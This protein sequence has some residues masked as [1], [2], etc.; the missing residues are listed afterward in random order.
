MSSP[1]WEPD[2]DYEDDRADSGRVGAGE[3]ARDNVSAPEDVNA[4]TREGESETP[5]Q[6]TSGTPRQSTSGT[7]RQSTSGTPHQSTSDPPELIDVDSDSEVSESV[8]G[9]RRWGI[10]LRGRGRG[11]GKRGR[12]R[13]ESRDRGGEGDDEAENEDEN[14]SAEATELFNHME[15]KYSFMAEK[16]FV[17]KDAVSKKDSKDVSLKFECRKCSSIYSADSCSLTNLRK[18]IQRVHDTSLTDYEKLW[19]NH[20]R[21]VDGPSSSKRARLTPT[22][23]DFFKPK[24]AAPEWTPIVTQGQ[25]DKAVVNFIIDCN[26]PYRYT[27]KES[28]KALVLLGMYIKH[29]FFSFQN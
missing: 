12:G 10:P 21:G 9:S 5:R 28:F 25:I 13:S 6:S 15:R 22:M 14:R 23:S 11:R 4:P 16:Y 27:E 2:L 17:L 24:K 7:P 1:T 19:E 3:S 8:R 29:N 26:A 20:R 18:H